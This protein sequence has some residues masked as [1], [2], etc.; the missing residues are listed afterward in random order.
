MLN[1]FLRY[2]AH[3]CFHL[4][5]MRHNKTK[6]VQHDTPR[7]NRLVGQV[8]AGRSIPEAAKE[9]QIPQSTAYSIVDR[10]RTT[11]STDNKPRSGR[12]SKVTP[13][14]GRMMEWKARIHR[15]TP[16]TNLVNL[17]PVKI[18]PRTLSRHL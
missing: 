3:L 2:H 10:Y 7:K 12:P 14:M 6:R 17:L 9:N 1:F 11:G 18:S 8:E 13:T 15:R 5:H 4:L 16:F